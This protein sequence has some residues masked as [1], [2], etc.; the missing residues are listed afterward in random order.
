MQVGLDAWNLNIQ[1]CHFA[2]LPKSIWLK[3]QP[4]EPN[5]NKSLTC[6]GLRF[7]ALTVALCISKS[8]HSN[9][10]RRERFSCKVWDNL[11]WVP[12]LNQSEVLTSLFCCKLSIPVKEEA[13]QHWLW[14]APEFLLCSL[15]LCNAINTKESRVNTKGYLFCVSSVSPSFYHF[16]MPGFHLKGRVFQ[17]RVA[18]ISF[19]HIFVR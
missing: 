17:C 8:G 18:Q 6:L 15:V 13:P 12:C 5:G 2:P 16:S 14:R 10:R 7:K 9:N 19:S 4:G 3:N 11:G 1:L